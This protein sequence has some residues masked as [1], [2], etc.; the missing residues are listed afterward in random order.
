MD[1]YPIVSQSIGFLSELHHCID[2]ADIQGLDQFIAKYSAC[3]IRA[4]ETYAKGLKADYASVKNA[5]LNRNINNGMIEGFNDKIKLMRKIRFGR[6]KEELINAVS[7]LS[8][9]AKFH[10]SDY[11]PIKHIYAKRVA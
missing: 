1:K 9:Q 4:F 11:T 7:V 10:Y 8:T 3:G 5:I 2:N 6:A